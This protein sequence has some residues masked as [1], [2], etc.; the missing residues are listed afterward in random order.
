MLTSIVRTLVPAWWASAVAWA[1]G[2][3]PALEPFRD[4]LLAQG[5]PLADFVALV[6]V[7]AVMAVLTASWY[8]FW[9]WL[10]PKLPGWLVTAV[11]GSR[12][13]PTYP[14]TAPDPQNLGRPSAHAGPVYPDED[15]H[16]GK[17]VAN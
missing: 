12:H 10:E 8:T 16:G 4:Q 11:L 2:I 15:P 13:A 5:T 7:P 14:T 6:I 9:R 17:H 1:L 3:V